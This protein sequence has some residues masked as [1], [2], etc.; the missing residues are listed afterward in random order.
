VPLFVMHQPLIRFR[1]AIQKAVAVGTAKM[2]ETASLG[3]AVAR[4]GGNPASGQK[5]VAE[6][7]GRHKSV[8]IDRAPER[9]PVSNMEME[10]VMVGW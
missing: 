7:A 4:L 6:R 2:S 9:M 5:L 8:R 10:S 3:E 1:Y